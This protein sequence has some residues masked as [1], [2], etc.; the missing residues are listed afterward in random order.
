MTGLQVVHA[1]QRTGWDPGVVLT[2]AFIAGPVLPGAY[3]VLLGVR[4]P[5]ADGS[6]GRGIAM[7]LVGAVGLALWAGLLAGPVLAVVAGVLVLAQ[8]A[9]EPAPA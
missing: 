5:R 8:R 9:R 6:A 3:A 2:L 4:S 7:V 1:V